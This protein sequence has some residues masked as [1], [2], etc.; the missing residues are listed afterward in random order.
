[1]TISTEEQASA[2]SARY[3]VRVRADDGAWQD[4]GITFFGASSTFSF[5]ALNVTGK[6]FQY[7]VRFQAGAVATDDMK[8]KNISFEAIGGKVQERWQ[9]VID[10]TEYLNVENLV[11]DPE[12][13]YAL[14]RSTLNTATPQAV[15]I[16][17]GDQ[18]QE[19]DADEA[20]TGVV[21]SI[22]VGKGAPTEA[23]I[24]VV[25]LKVF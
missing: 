15:T 23:Y 18:M 1:M 8:M 9:F 22:E 11:Q 13:V 21:E 10:A 24:T 6:Q 5:S 20:F 16:S 12:E 17:H 3:G 14:F 4:L 19:P 2:N 7:E 25:M